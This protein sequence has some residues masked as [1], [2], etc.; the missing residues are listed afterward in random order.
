MTGRL[1]RHNVH[2]PQHCCEAMTRRL[3]WRC[4][5]HADRYDCADASFTAKFQEYGLIIHDGGSSSIVISYCPW[6]GARLPASQRDRWFTEMERVGIDPWTGDIPA[7]YQDDRWMH[8]EPGTP[9]PS[10]PGPTDLRR[11]LSP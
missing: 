3:D 11:V 2:M 7:E 5:T 8:S 4:D 6:C 1:P 10:R 9:A